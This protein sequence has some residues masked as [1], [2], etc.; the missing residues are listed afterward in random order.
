M[1]ETYFKMRFLSFQKFVIPRARRF[2]TAQ[3]DESFRI[4]ANFLQA[5]PVSIRLK[6]IAF[7]VLTDFL[8]FCFFG[9]R[10]K[11]VKYLFD[12]SVPLLRKGFWG[13]NILAT[14]FRHTLG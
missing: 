10:Q 1:L 2:T 5:R 13:V 7:L 8:T 14:G 9:Q 12:S 4:V 3:Q 11:V 6:V